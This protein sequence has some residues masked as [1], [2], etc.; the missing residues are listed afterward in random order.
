M[1]QCTRFFWCI[2]AAFR[3]ALERKAQY[4]GWCNKTSDTL[5]FGLGRHIRE[6]GL[7]V[8]R[9]AFKWGHKPLNAPL[10]AP[11]WLVCHLIVE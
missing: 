5:A 7:A 4:K 8:G 2:R 3:C 1:A 10:I 11:F 9:L 6:R